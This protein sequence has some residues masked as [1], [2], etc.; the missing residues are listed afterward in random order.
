MAC[1]EEPTECPEEPIPSIDEA[2]DYPAPTEYQ[3]NA[4]LEDCDPGGYSSASNFPVQQY[5]VQASMEA[6]VV[7]EIAEVPPN[8][9]RRVSEPAVEELCPYRASHILEGAMW[10]RCRPCREFV[11]KVAQ[12]LAGPDLRG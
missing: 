6:I 12:Q 2:Q 10:E 1:D 9:T 8:G 7:T 5:P 3:D 11:R 4:F